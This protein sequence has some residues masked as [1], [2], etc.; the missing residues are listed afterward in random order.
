M[1]QGQRLLV[2]LLLLVLSTVSAWADLRTF[3]LRSS[4]PAELVQVLR[5]HLG[6]GA[7]VSAFRNRLV[8]QGTPEQMALAQQL[9]AE[10][11]SERPMLLVEVRQEV[12]QAEAGT[13]VRGTIR[14]GTG[15]D[16]A[17][18]GAQRTL[19]NSTRNLTQS[20]RVLLG[21]PALIRI[22]QE[23]PYVASWGVVSGENQGATATTAYQATEQGYRILPE[24]LEGEQVLLQVNLTMDAADPQAAG[25]GSGRAPAVDR[26][27][28]ATKIRVPLGQWINLS[29]SL[30]NDRGAEDAI[31]SW[32]T[33]RQYERYDVWLR[34]QR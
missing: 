8:V 16:A 2:I 19:S 14:L 30:R 6:E 31:L 17:R 21:E 32:R 24:R 11:D 20:L 22:G 28:V 3:T 12:R 18:L 5:D 15:P 4:D 33:G 26:R 27:D 23:A 9:V 1:R 25:E 10:L 34:L 7:R 29:Q 13:D